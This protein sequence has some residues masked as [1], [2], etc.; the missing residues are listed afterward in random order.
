MSAIPRCGDVEGAAFENVRT[1][2]YVTSI[3]STA[4]GVD[5]RDSFGRSCRDYVV[6]LDF[7]LVPSPDGYHA[8]L[9]SAFGTS[10]GGAAQTIKV[11]TR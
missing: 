10:R 4:P 7:R 5:V 11:V 1:E 9:W 3:T 8:G 2:D 6:V